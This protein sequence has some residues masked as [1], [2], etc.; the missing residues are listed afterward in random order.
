MSLDIELPPHWPNA[1]RR[2]SPKTVLV[3]AMTTFGGSTWSLGHGAVPPFGRPQRR[4][5]RADPC[6]KRRC[7]RLFEAAVTS[8]ITSRHADDTA[9]TRIPLLVNVLSI[10]E[11]TTATRTV[12]A[13]VLRP[14]SECTGGPLSLSSSHSPFI[15]YPIIF[16]LRRLATHLC[17]L[18]GSHIVKTDEAIRRRTSAA[19]SGDQGD[20][21]CQRVDVSRQTVLSL[22]ES[23]HLL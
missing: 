14:V 6:I 5:G 3:D 20:A 10:H 19:P 17:F 23:R 11:R 1:D 7:R 9:P 4:H 12:S 15:R 8:E 22:G 16:V 21:T 2:L 13:V 18:L